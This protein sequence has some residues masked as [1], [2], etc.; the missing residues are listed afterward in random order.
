MAQA[1]DTCINTN[2]GVFTRRRSPTLQTPCGPVGL[3]LYGRLNRKSV[4]GRIAGGRALKIGASHERHRQYFNDHVIFTISFNITYA[5]LP[6]SF[7]IPTPGMAAAA[8]VALRRLDS[9]PDSQNAARIRRIGGGMPSRTLTRPS[10]AQK[11]MEDKEVTINAPAL[12]KSGVRTSKLGYEDKLITK[13]VS[14]FDVARL[15]A[16]M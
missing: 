1:R 15:P 13:I 7:A 14:I 16:L 2:L 8:S 9:G 12:S 10:L 6:N 5:A 11:L 4:A 3:A